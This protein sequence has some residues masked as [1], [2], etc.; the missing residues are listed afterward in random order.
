MKKPTKS[1]KKKKAAAAAKKTTTGAYRT[2]EKVKYDNFALLKFDE[3]MEKNLMI[4]W[5]SLKP[6]I[7]K[8]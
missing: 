1:T 2:V 4:S 8:T 7:R 6:F 5:K 3:L